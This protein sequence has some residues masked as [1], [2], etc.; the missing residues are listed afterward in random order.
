MDAPFADRREAGRLLG[1]A[2]AARA[3]I[4]N[5]TIVLALPRGGV[6]VGFEVAAALD[7]PLAVFVVRKLGVPWHPELAMGALASG[8]IRY[9]DELLMRQLGVSQAQLETVVAREAVELS[10][11]EALYHAGAPLPSLRERPVVLVDD[12]LA[13][14]ATMKAAVRAVRAQSPRRT[15]VAVP[16]GAPDTCAA[17][18]EEADEVVCLRMPPDFRAVGL[19]YTRF[20][21]TTDA[22]VRSLLE[23]AAAR[24]PTS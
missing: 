9:V 7:A 14:G 12:G 1:E 15:I 22:E 11:R 20:D 16:V 6:P 2:L 13:T 4:G 17:L 5:G 19:W 8:G 24:R 21:Q 18:R 10:R 23:Q 3:S